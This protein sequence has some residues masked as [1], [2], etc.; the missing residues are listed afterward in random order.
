MYTEILKV[1]SPRHQ[2]FTAYQAFLEW[3]FDLLKSP[4]LTI[5]KDGKSKKLTFRELIINSRNKIDSTNTEYYTIE[6]TRLSGVHTL[7]KL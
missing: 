1:G 2:C 6:H 7:M 5:T 3:N 4:Y